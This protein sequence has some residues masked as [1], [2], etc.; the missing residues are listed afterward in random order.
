MAEN[1]GI[2]WTH[3]TFN[4]WTACTKVSPGCTNCYAEDWANRW[5]PK[6]STVPAWGPRAPR[7]LT[8]D[9]T[10]R[11]PFKWQRTAE[12]EGTIKRV[13]TASLADVFDD[14]KSID[15]AWRSRLW[16]LI[17][18]TPWL[19]WLVLTKRPENLGFLP[20]LSNPIPNMR[21]G[22]TVEN[23][24]MANVRLPYLLAL[25]ANGWPTF[26]SYE[27]ALS[28]VNWYP[29]QDSIGWLIAGGE[30]GP[31]ARRPDIN[32]FRDA[33]DFSQDHDIPFFFKQFG[34]FDAAGQKVG[35][36]KAGKELDGVEHLNFPPPLPIHLDLIAGHKR[37][38]ALQ[39]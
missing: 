30:S 18:Q 5:A 7:Q 29:W 32:W 13:F 21:I 1:S 39:M 31:H 3:H 11:Q 9:S 20:D 22:V 33:R 14:H 15:P 6:G 36:K 16:L 17:E 26:V 12:R 28:H 34:T 25:A 8:S 2:E 23:Q 19:E 35:K 38:S 27:P 37:Q 10:W 24:D 4:G